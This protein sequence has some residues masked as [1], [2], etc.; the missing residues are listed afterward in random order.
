MLEEQEK[1]VNTINEILC[2][3]KHAEMMLRDMGHHEVSYG[4]DG[5]EWKIEVRKHKDKKEAT[6]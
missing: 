3:F 5:T 4:M 1:Q 6:K 2:A